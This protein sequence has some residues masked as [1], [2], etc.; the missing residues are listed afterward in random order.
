MNVVQTLIK[1]VMQLAVYDFLSAI[2]VFLL[3]GWQI[4]LS[5][6][7]KGIGAKKRDQFLVSKMEFIYF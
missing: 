2:H 3:K 6:H 4:S 5:N 1:V 7:E